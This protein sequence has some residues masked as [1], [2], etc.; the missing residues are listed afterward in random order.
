MDLKRRESVCHTF[1]G[2]FRPAAAAT[3]LFYHR[4][5]NGVGD[6]VRKDAGGQA[7]DHLGHTNFMCCQQHVVVD[8]EIVSLE[9]MI[10]HYAG[11]SKAC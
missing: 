1:A 5:V 2:A 8:G 6:L 3:R 10:G 11:G 4:L 9:E 7:G